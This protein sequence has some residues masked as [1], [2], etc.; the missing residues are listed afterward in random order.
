MS[1]LALLIVLALG[2][3]GVALHRAPEGCETR[4]GF[5]FTR[6]APPLMKTIRRLIFCRFGNHRR[7]IALDDRGY[8]GAKLC[9]DCGTYLPSVQWPV[10]PAPPNEITSLGGFI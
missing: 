4:T 8:A 7:P 1:Y 9:A 3:I 5:H 6:P 2:A 10:K